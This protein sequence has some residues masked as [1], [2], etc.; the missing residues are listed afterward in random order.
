MNDLSKVAHK[1]H[2]LGLQLGVDSHDLDRIRGAEND[3]KTCLTSMLTYWLDNNT[4]AHRSQ[5]VEMLTSAAINEQSLAR[6]L[7]NSRGNVLYGQGNSHR[8]VCRLYSYMY[9]YSLSI[10]IER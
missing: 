9:L 7:K 1:W 5:I 8:Q 10:I 6:K 4:D 2:A 3:A